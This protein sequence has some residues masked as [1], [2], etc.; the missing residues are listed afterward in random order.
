MRFR[1][2]VGAAYESGAPLADA[3]K[4][5]NYYIE[6]I[7][8]ESEYADAETALF[9]TPGF[10]LF[11]TPP[12]GNGR[13]LFAQNDRTFGVVGD[14][15]VEIFPDGT[16]VTRAL[17]TLTDFT[18]APTVTPSPLTPALMQPNPP[19]VQQG[20]AIGSTTYGYKIVAKNAV[21]S[22]V[23]SLEGLIS[24]GNATL[25]ANNF[26][27]ITWDEASV[28]NA[29]GVDV[30]RTTGGTAPPKRIGTITDVS[31]RFFQDTGMAGTAAVPPTVDTSAGT[32]GAT[33]WGYKVAAVLGIGTTA[34]SAEG[35]T[36]TGQAAL[37]S[38]HFNII[39]WPAVANAQGYQ[40]F[41]TSGPGVTTPKLIGEIADAT[42]LEFHDTGM[43]GETMTPPGGNTTVGMS[44]A[45]DG[46][47][48]SMASS[49]DAGQQII[50]GASGK[51]YLFDLR[52]NVFAQVLDGVTFI[53][54]LDAYFV[55]LDA[56]TSTFRWSRLLNGFFWSGLDQAQRTAGAD[57]WVAMAVQNKEVWL[58]GSQTTEV[59]V[60]S[61]G[62]NA[63]API[64]HVYI[65]D[66]TGAPFSLV[67]VEGSLCW[68]KQDAQGG[69][70]VVQSDGYRINRISD[71]ALEAAM[72]TYP[73]LADAE[74]FTYQDLGHSFYVLSFPAAGQTWGYDT[75]TQRWHQRAHHTP[76]SL[77]EGVYRPRAHA[78]A[79]SGL[80]A[81]LHLVIDR[82]NGA[83]YE[84]SSE[85]GLDIDDRP[86]VR[87]R[88]AP[89]I[90][91]GGKMVVHHDLKLE[92]E[93]VVP[94]PSGQGSEPTMM[95]RWA[96]GRV[97]N[98]SYEHW[99]VVGL[100]EEEETKAEWL[101]LGATRKRLYELT[102]SDPIPWKILGAQINAR[103]G[104]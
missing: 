88:R 46:S 3:Q 23:A 62:T 51:A 102:V 1:G 76:N 100:N 66:G 13:G 21:G 8:A 82:E 55:A 94:L 75:T 33:T 14:Q 104:R 95:L 85:F 98:W 53:D 90:S 6:N 72:R 50:I 81:G 45:N 103:S 7:R 37:D 42:I 60:K 101:N 61:S 18:A 43:A 20:G 54:Y 44:L 36:T 30:Y 65:E 15:L 10:R 48:V 78:F 11:S 38:V 39:A 69:G 47:P 57:K 68:L 31:I 89:W 96:D 56:A 49:G 58:V 24:T 19:T 84:M 92:I 93:S 79:F 35:T 34:A 52:T 32:V 5:V 97:G 25:D 83:I 91:N 86:I 77:L 9:P 59:W 73:T 67:R 70:I 26:N 64:D 29:T 80:T 12:T 87:M 17:S 74:G 16:W 99:T 71:H 22:S 27:H 63:F 40:V 41:R 2:F 28:Q 4:L